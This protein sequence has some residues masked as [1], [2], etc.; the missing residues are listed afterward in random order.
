MMGSFSNHPLSAFSRSRL[1]LDSTCLD[2]LPDSPDC[3]GKSTLKGQGAA[4][5]HVF[6]EGTQNQGVVLICPDSLHQMKDLRFV[7][8]LNKVTYNFNLRSSA[9]DHAPLSH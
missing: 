1:S 9:P 7:A 2:L 5:L 8:H 3:E 6:L 4:K